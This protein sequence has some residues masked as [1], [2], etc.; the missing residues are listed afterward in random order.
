[1]GTLVFRSEPTKGIMKK[2]TV[3]LESGVIETRFYDKSGKLIEIR[4]KQPPADSYKLPG[5][6]HHSYTARND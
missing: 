3:E 1:M 5:L 2:K 6:L 4:R